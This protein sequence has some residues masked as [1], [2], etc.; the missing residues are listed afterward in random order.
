MIHGDEINQIKSNEGRLEVNAEK[1]KYMLLSRHQNAVQSLD[2]EIAHR[3]FEN[4]VQFGYLRTT[5]T[6]ENLIEEKIKRKLNS[7]NAC[8]HS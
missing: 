3:S 5:V 8:T 4:V 1:S 7:G 6:N 2:I